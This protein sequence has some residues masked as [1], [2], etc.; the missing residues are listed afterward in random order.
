[1]RSIIYHSIGEINRLSRRWLLPSGKRLR[2]VQVVCTY[3]LIGVYHVQLAEHSH[4]RI[5]IVRPDAT[6]LRAAAVADKLVYLA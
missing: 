4:R 1:M 3:A 6:E 2:Y 5:W